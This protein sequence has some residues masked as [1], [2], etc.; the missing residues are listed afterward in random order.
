MKILSVDDSKIIR[1]IIKNA[2]SIFGYEMLE[3]GNGKEA[4]DILE[5][6][7]A[8][9]G[10]ILLDWN[11]PVMDGITALKACKADARFAHIPVIMVTTESERQK[12]VEA[13]SAGAKN[14]VMKPFTQETIQSKI[15]ET[16]GAA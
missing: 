1:Q 3:A 8:N 15:I 10:L 6:E 16:I 12:V 13:V 11:M 4:L 9:V 2:I 7:H 14:Y 5:K